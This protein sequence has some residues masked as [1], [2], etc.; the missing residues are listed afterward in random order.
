MPRVEFLRRLVARA[1]RLCQ[2]VD[3]GKMILAYGCQLLESVAQF[4]IGIG[5]VPELVLGGGETFL[6]FRALG[7]IPTQCVLCVCKGVSKIMTRQIA[8]IR[9][10]DRKRMR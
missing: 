1:P 7:E 6:D 2:D 9:K 4:R 10:A 3:G 8:T 5:C